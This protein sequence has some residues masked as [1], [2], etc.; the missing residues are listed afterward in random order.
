LPR[1]FLIIA[2]AFRNSELCLLALG[3]RLSSE[4]RRSPPAGQPFAGTTLRLRLKCRRSLVPPLSTPPSRHLRTESHR[5]LRGIET[6]TR[7]NRGRGCLD[8]WC[9]DGTER[10]A[11]RWL[12]PRDARPRL[13]LTACEPLATFCRENHRGLNTRIL[14]SRS[15][16]PGYLPVAD[17]SNAWRKGS[18]VAGCP[19][20]R[21]NP[22]V[23]QPC[24]PT[25]W[26]PRIC[27]K[28][29]H[30][31]CPRGVAD[32]TVPGTRL[33]N[34]SLGPSLAHFSQRAGNTRTDPNRCL[35]P[36]GRRFVY[37]RPT[38]LGH[39]GARGCSWSPVETPAIVPLPGPRGLELVFCGR[40]WTFQP[41][42]PGFADLY[43]GLPSNGDTRWPA[44][45]ERLVGDRMR[46]ECLEAPRAQG[47][48]SA[49]VV[50]S[51]RPSPSK[52]RNADDLVALS[53]RGALRTRHL[54]A[55]RPPKHW[56]LR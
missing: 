39:P 42:R 52:R 30:R 19:E 31:L 27:R 6:D 36:S 11:H 32:T 5:A 46:P 8:Y 22:S 9:A 48:P 51:M 14:P 41:P 50:L 49:S 44:L 17:V 25:F 4:R 23:A 28:C 18:R 1:A 13:F 7:L 15:R 12:S 21:G 35:S 29:S 40:A 54:G 24:R 47:L 20:E 34:P 2:P 26:R 56:G 53:P 37:F 38:T 55:R 16:P 10:R 43:P 33:R 45:G 3:R